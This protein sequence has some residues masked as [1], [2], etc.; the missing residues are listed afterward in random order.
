[1]T[2]VSI[3][4]HSGANAS[5][6]HK[7]LGIV[8]PDTGEALEQFEMASP[9]RLNSFAS[10]N[11]EFAFGYSR[12]PPGHDVEVLERV[13]EAGGT[14]DAGRKLAYAGADAVVWACTSGSFIG[15]LAKAKTQLR[16][17]QGRI[18]VPVTTAAL[19]L[20]SA[21][22]RLGLQKIDILSPYP[23]DVSGIFRDFMEDA[24]FE[25]V[26]LLPLGSPC[27]SASASLDLIEECRPLASMPG[28]AIII[29]DT[30]TNTLGNVAELETAAGKPVLT[31]NQAC[32]FE[33]AL[34]AGARDAVAG[35]PA[36]RRLADTSAMGAT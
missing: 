20:M 8:W 31:V 33:G 4:F 2:G 11:L 10:G 7:R 22:D 28:E 24:G 26:S 17:L 3:P 25:V 13:A 30:A 18:G 14:A 36:L 23:M 9:S 34:L 21:A 16:D 29:P 35:I 19:A 1:M 32:L 15:G 27:A 5:E 12:V 6:R